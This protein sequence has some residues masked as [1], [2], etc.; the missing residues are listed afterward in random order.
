MLIS[1]PISSFE[2]NPNIDLQFDEA[3]FIV[4][5]FSNSVTN[6]IAAELLGN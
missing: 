2:L 6:T 1:L 3:L 4:L 5:A